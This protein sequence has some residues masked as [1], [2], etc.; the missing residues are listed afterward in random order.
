MN[1]NMI[2]H[3][4][5]YYTLQNADGHDLVLSVDNHW[6]T[7]SMAAEAADMACKDY[8][9]TILVRK[10]VSTIVRAFQAVVTVKEVSDTSVVAS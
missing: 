5:E 10:H 1:K 9:D 6:L 4:L 8:K 2:G 3:E 7:E